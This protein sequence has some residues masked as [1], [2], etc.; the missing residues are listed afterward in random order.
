M[1]FTVSVGNVI[2]PVNCCTW[3]ILTLYCVGPLLKSV[4]IEMAI[5]ACVEASVHGR[6]RMIDIFFKK[7]LLIET[8]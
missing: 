1:E 3:V 5:R 6:S 7:Y 8:R 4:S 2:D